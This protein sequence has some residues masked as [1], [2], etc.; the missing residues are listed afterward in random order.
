MADITIVNG[1]YKPTNITGGHHPASCTILEIR[2]VFLLVVTYYSL[3]V[4]MK[5]D[6]AEVLARNRSDPGDNQ[7]SRGAETKHDSPLDADETW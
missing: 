3:H 5:K 2:F 4:T 7:A 1:V 6:V